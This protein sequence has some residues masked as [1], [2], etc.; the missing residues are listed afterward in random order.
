MAGGSGESTTDSGTGTYGFSRSGAGVRGET[1][2][3]VGVQG[4]AFQGGGAGRFFGN[5]EVTGDITLVGGQDCAEEFTVASTTGAKVIEP[6][7]V[8]VI[9]EAGVLEESQT[10]YDKRVAG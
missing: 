8:L 10:A 5:V 9:S 6:G 3:G 4:Q 2:T 1:N 7:T